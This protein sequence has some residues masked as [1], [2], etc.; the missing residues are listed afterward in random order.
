[1]TTNQHPL[2]EGLAPFSQEAEQAVIG[3]VLVNPEI[4]LTLVT[5]L[6]TGDFYYLR[7]GY[8]WDALHR[9]YDR[10]DKLDY[11]T[12][13]D[14]LR[15][16]NRLEEV[17][18]SP[19][20]LYL[21]NNTPNAYHAESYAR[22]VERAAIRRRMLA[23]ADEIKELARDEQ[24]S[25]EDAQVMA[26]QCLDKAVS[27]R[28]TRSRYL[29]GALSIREY[30]THINEL[31]RRA[32]SG[33]RIGIPL[34]EQWVTLVDK[35]PAVYPGDFT[36]VSGPSGGGKSAFLEAW[37]EWVASLGISVSYMHTEMST[38]QVLHRRM[39]RWSGLPFHTLA[40][41]DLKEG[42]YTRMMNADEEIGRWAGNIAYHWLPDVKFDVLATEMRRAHTQGVRVFFL[43]HFQDVQPAIAGKGDNEI[44]AYERAVTWLA[45]FAEKRQC[46]V[47]VASQ[48]NE[49]GKT[50]WTKKLIEKASLWI[51]MS[52][53]RLA[54]EYAYV[55]RG[56]ECHSLPGED[57]PVADVFVNKARF[58]KKAKI[59]MVY[60]GSQFLWLDTR[61]ARRP[62]GWEG[63]KVVNFAE[64]TAQAEE[65]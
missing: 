41:G 20:L 17:G 23:A 10:D 8:I 25:T 42:M 14:E 52:R 35:V 4:F 57:S 62:S 7:H 26:L 30:D 6:Q 33:E 56:V 65:R 2:A 58:G 9:I 15:T 55:Y 21:T 29:P 36:V 45:A 44:R 16:A 46:V 60:H 40:G 27:S 19:Y 47:I 22:L 24:L 48:E 5:I 18:G 32:E 49:Q 51:R 59:K 31:V 63:A 54:S 61:E 43:D 34:P 50:K 12:L 13:V 28:G 39:S 3:A 37:T 38:E 53:K 11:V 64:A 1:M